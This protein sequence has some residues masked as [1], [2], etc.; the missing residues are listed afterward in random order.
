MPIS[1]DGE[2]VLVGI[3]TWSVYDLQLLDQ[4]HATL[5][6]GNRLTII[7]IFDVDACNSFDDFERYVPDI[8]R[9]LRTPVVGVWRNGAKISSAWGAAGRKLLAEIGLVE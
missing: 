1:A 7:D 5:A 9:V 6:G 2:R 4:L 3:A 8:G